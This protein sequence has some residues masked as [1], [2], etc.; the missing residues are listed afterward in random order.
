MLISEYKTSSNFDG[1]ATVFNVLKTKLNWKL[2]HS[3]IFLY[4]VVSCNTRN[5]ARE[6]PSYKY[7]KGRIS[8]WFTTYMQ[9][10]FNNEVIAYPEINAKTKEAF[11]HA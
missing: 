6:F 2:N 5:T 7:N 11:R 4:F 10:K 9:E 1:I 8:F 3:I